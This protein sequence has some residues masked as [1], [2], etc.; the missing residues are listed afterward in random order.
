MQFKVTWAMLLFLTFVMTGCHSDDQKAAVFAKDAYPSAYEHPAT[1][2]VLL[3][4]A[5]IYTGNGGFIEKGFVLLQD[6]RIVHVGANRP[7]LPAR[8]RIIEAMGR[9]VTPGLID[10]HSHLGDY[11]SPEVEAHQMATRCRMPIPL[12]YV[13]NM[14]S[15]HRT[16][17]FIGHGK[18][19]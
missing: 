18:A 1:S 6:G 8:T 19:V 4:Y 16:P 12:R 17:V 11:P 15:G 3:Q 9:F 10:P 5:A 2:P 14:V 13:P 7:R